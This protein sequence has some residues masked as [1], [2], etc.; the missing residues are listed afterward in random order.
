MRPPVDLLVPRARSTRSRGLMSPRAR[1]ISRSLVVVALTFVVA[2]PMQAQNAATSATPLS[3]PITFFGEVRSRTE[4]DAPGGGAT[5]DVF[6]MLRS[7]FGARVDPAR[8]LS[9]MLQLQDSRVLGTEGNRLSS[10]VDVFDLHQGYLQLVTPWRGS[11][12][13]LRA[14]RQEIALGNERLVGAVNWSNTGRTFDGARVF[15]TP[16]GPAGAD[17]WSV[18]TF[19]AVMEENGRRFGAATNVAATP[20]HFVL[21]AFASR[22]AP[23][24]PGADVTV[25]YD[26]GAAYRSYADAHRTTTDARLR[27][28]LPFAVRVEV[29][30]AV[31][32]GAQSYVPATGAPS[33]QRV[34]AWLA[35]ARLG[36]AIGRGV[37]TAGVDMLSGDDAPSDARYSAFGTMFGTNHPFYG[38][39]DLIGDPAATTKERGLRDAFVNAAH[40]LTTWLSPRAELH[41]FTLA[42][43]TERRLGVEAD[44]VAPFRLAA[45][46]SL[47]LG[48]ALFRA[49]PAAQPLGLGTDRSYRKWGYAQ[50]R[51]GF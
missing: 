20:D 46:T 3:L 1:T 12:I 28:L 42:A 7:R 6:T 29:E 17:R 8:G 23:G 33:T 47:E 22:G 21:G 14:G 51:A 4:W 37:A 10:A 30:G 13:G 49:G 15:L 44:L 27:A 31:Q 24:K 48:Y 39:L 26:A 5:A 36:H 32:T 41:R 35:G 40:P 19:A 16:A 9:V 34:R 43:G 25:L 11:E 50:L 18:T 45:G 38:L 2:A